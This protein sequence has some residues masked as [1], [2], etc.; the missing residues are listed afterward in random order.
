MKILPAK[1][2]FENYNNF[3]CLV[4]DQIKILGPNLKLTLDIVKK[5][6]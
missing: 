3:P 4:E 5:V 2:D 1:I 6:K